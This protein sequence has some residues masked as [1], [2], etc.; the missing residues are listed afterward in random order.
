MSSTDDIPLLERP[1]FFDG[2]RL[3]A[4]DL[5]ATQTY[6]RELRWLHNRSLHG[7]GIAF[8]FAI[9]GTRGVQSVKVDIG[10]AIDRI[11]RDLILD[12]P[13]EM[14]IPSVASASDGSPAIYYLTVSYADDA[15]LNPT[16]R[17]GACN[18]SGA[19]R[20]PEMPL[21]RW[22]DPNDT[23]PSS[24]YRFGLDVVLASIHIQNCQLAAEVSTRERRDALPS[25]QPYVAAGSTTKG[26][27]VWRLWPND[28]AP[29]GVVTTVTTSGAGFQTTPRYQA[30]VVGERMFKTADG[31]GQ[32]NS[33]IVDGY[34]QV[35]QTT[36]SSFDLR[37]ML[38]R[39]I[40]VGLRRTDDVFV[41]Q[42]YGAV[43]N[44][45]NSG[46][47]TEHLLQINGPQLRVG[48]ELLFEP[49]KGVLVLFK[50]LT[51][52][53]FKGPFEKISERNRTSLNELLGANGW[54]INTLE[55]SISQKIIIPG[56]ALTI[57][58]TRVQEPAFMDVLKKN[59]EWHVVWTGVE[60]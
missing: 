13:V 48:Q 44:H 47:S 16:T 49:Q 7:W 28:S 18:T 21:I 9:A 54:D 40:T 50:K 24:R 26:N 15:Q 27:T 43:V 32:N 10:Y 30:H 3:M 59:L 60:G 53:N 56:P 37:V 38:P 6:N 25:Q 22:Q 41:I 58:P 34:A 52:Q 19:V 39:G 17:T 2:Q 35:A 46:V 12:A 20:R 8:G 5:A 33:F 4:Y 23:N 14:P 57:N 51:S 29:V 55:V 11:G 45:L 36:A 42:D 31:S 1:A